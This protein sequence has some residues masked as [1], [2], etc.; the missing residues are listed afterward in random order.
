MEKPTSSSNHFKK[1]IAAGLA[2]TALAVGGHE[3]V[4]ANQPDH[5]SHN[6]S[7]LAESIDPSEA[8]QEKLASLPDQWA[9]AMEGWPGQVAIAVYD[10]DS[11][12]TAE[13]STPGSDYFSSASI[14]KYAILVETLRQKQT[15]GEDL[16]DYELTQAQLMIQ[17]SDNPAAS[18]LWDQVGGAR[19]MQNLFDSLDMN[20]TK[21]SPS[22]G[23][24]STTAADQ[25]Q[26]LKQLTPLGTSLNSQ[27][28]E[29]MN[30]ILA[31]VTTSQRWGVSGGVPE[32]IAVD[33]K[34][35]WLNDSATTNEYASS[36]SWTVNSIGK[37]GDEY[38][39]AILSEGNPVGSEASQQ[40]GVNRLEILSQITW[41]SLS[42]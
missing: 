39:I 30:Q 33:L 3:V 5:Y 34:N 19:A 23:V 9:E 13:W 32:A 10:L 37:V 24:T 40:N 42:E 25:L 38:L 27:S 8:K 31:D 16:T 14:I 6:H 35:G 18:Y 26:I 11:G 2:G 4:Q 15:T 17:Q 22:W 29:Q 36:S 20:S 28:I 1:L 7:D 21:A 12:Q 41:Q